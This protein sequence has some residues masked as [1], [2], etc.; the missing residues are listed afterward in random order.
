MWVLSYTVHRF[1]AKIQSLTCTTYGK[2]LQESITSVLTPK[3]GIVFCLLL[4]PKSEAIVFFLPLSVDLSINSLHNED[5][6][7]GLMPKAFYPIHN[8]TTFSEISYQSNIGFWLVTC[9]L[10]FLNNVTVPEWE[11]LYVILF[12]SQRF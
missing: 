6:T 7:L 4:A 8:S 9:K 1:H 5:K 12:P 2:Y 10:N 11:S 3:S